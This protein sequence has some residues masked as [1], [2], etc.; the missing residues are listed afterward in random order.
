ME[1]KNHVA[2]VLE[3]WQP[4]DCMLEKVWLVE[5][6]ICF[7]WFLPEVGFFEGGLAVVEHNAYINK[8]LYALFDIVDVI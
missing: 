4:Y 6:F 7:D 3:A 2:F 8:V 1:F 5:D